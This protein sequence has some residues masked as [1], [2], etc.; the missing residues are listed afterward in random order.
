MSANNEMLASVRNHF[1]HWAGFL[2]SVEMT[3][4]QVF[5]SAGWY[6]KKAQF[7]FRQKMPKIIRAEYILN[8]AEQLCYFYEFFVSVIWVDASIFR[9]R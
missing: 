2:T 6:Y 1:A 9:N 4:N 3:K 5:S 8:K 7:D